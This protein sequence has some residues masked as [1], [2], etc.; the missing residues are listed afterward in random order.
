MILKNRQTPIISPGIP[1]MCRNQRNTGRLQ[2]D[3]PPLHKPA[4]HPLNYRYRWQNPR[5]RR[6]RRAK[7]TKDMQTEENGQ[8]LSNS[9]MDFPSQANRPDRRRDENAPHKVS[10]RF[11]ADQRCAFL[12]VDK[13]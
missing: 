1:G 13:C 6:H 9:S 3:R 7:G 5:N 10:H 2:C 8:G 4:L 12:N 11:A